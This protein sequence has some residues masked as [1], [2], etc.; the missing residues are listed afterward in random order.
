MQVYISI[1]WDDVN[2]YMELLV[3]DFNNF[4]KYPLCYNVLV[5]I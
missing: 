1:E 2:L 5:H 4:S 3:Y